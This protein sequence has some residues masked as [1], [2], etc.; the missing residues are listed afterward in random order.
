M[1]VGGYGGVVR[2]GLVL[3]KTNLYDLVEKKSQCQH[4]NFGSCEIFN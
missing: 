4:I 3:Q 1:C 2:W